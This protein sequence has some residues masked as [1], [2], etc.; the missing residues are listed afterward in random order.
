M[1]RPELVGGLKRALERGYSLEQAKNSFISAG[2]N[3]EDIEDSI[4]ELLGIAE[5]SKY[6]NTGKT[7]I[8]YENKIASGS[9]KAPVNSG[10]TVV[11][12]PNIVQSNPQKKNNK[13]IIILVVIFLAL[14][15]IL[16]GTLLFKNSIISFINNMSS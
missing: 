7:N 10:N 6:A 8:N 9:I 1:Q 3:I 11:N 15:G 5:Y 16:L 4:A 2:Y 12:T 14:V 13:L